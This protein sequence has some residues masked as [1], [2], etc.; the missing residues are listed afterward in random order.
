MNKLKIEKRKKKNEMKEGRQEERQGQRERDREVHLT[1][2]MIPPH[3][4]IV[5]FH[6][7]FCSEVSIRDVKLPNLLKS[8]GGF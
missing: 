1:F 5:N 4:P 6:S 8:L 2:Y 7:L 3:S